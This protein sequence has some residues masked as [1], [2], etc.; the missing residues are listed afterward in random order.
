M[1]GGIA[2]LQLGRAIT[3][4]VVM[5]HHSDQAANAFTS[6]P[7]LQL[8]SWGIYGVDFFFVLSGFI[9]YHV[10]STDLRNAGAARQYALKRIIRIYVA[11]LPVGLGMVALYLA[12]PGLSASDRSWGLFTS[13]TLLP[14]PL[15]PALSVAWTLVFELMFYMVF[16]LFYLTR[17]FW[18]L[19]GLWV[20]WV[21]ATRVVGIDQ[22]SSALSHLLHPLVLE[23]VCGMVAALAVQKVPPGVGPAFLVPAVA[24]LVGFAALLSAGMEPNRAWLGLPLACLVAALVLLERAGRFRP[25]AGPVV[26]LGAASYAIY[27]VHNPIASVMARLL[28]TA[29]TW[30]A[31]FA[32]S[33]LAGILVGCVYHLA[34]ER[35]LLSHLR[36]WI[37]P[38]RRPIKAVAN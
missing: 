14:S 4:L 22:Q 37:L 21:Q 34:W 26:L 19:V 3:A 27:L 36:A 15:P 20:A 7:D 23:F 5:L 38:A 11:Y 17:H 25:S 24:G 31:S 10:H 12:I 32:T 29:D 30:A 35:P 2:S 9:I 13:A 18:G 33:V 6:Q 28:R 1:T 8:F 16:L